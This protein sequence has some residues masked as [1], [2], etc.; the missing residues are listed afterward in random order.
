MKKIIVVLLMASAMDVAT[1]ASP[2][3]PLRVSRNGRHL[4][5][6]KGTPFLI[7]GDAPWSMTVNLTPT[8]M[9]TYFDDRAAK[10]MNTII[11]RVLDHDPNFD[12]NESPPG[13]PPQDYNGNQPFTKSNGDW[14]RRNEAYWQT[15][16]LLLAKA[17]A[18]DMLVLAAAAYLGNGCGGEGWCAEMLSQ[19]SAAMYDYGQF[20]GARYASQGNI[21][22]VDGG[23]ADCNRTD[24]ACDRVRGVRDGIESK[25]TAYLRTAHG[26]HGDSSSAEYPWITLRSVYGYSHNGEYIP[27]LLKLEYDKR[28]TRPVFMIESAYEN[29]HSSVLKDWASQS[30]WS[31]L[32]GGTGAVFGNRPIWL[33]DTGWD[34]SS[35]IDSPGSRQQGHI[36]DL[37]RS[38]FWWALIPDYSST[39]VTQG[40][41][42][43]TSS[44]YVPAARTANG[45]TVMAYIPDG[46]EVTVDMTQLSGSTAKAWWFDPVSAA[47]SLIGTFET[48]GERVF[49]PPFS[50]CVLVLD[51]AA[52]G[53]AAPGTTVY[54]F[55]GSEIARPRS[56]KPTA[57]RR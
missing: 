53:L 25:T 23:D 56:R 52:K 5:D 51:D 35:G 57:V 13:S 43:L 33:F 24:S 18:H 55:E 40:R 32:G 31:M 54:P 50:S 8:Q 47:T 3:W 20:I 10:G 28:P 9:D 12:Q 14:S 44:G 27:A 49:A 26:Q 42:S 22:W 11:L 37:M 45:E 6:Q 34:A 21:I 48:A 38:R 15:V 4:E 1:L 46:G 41:G 7:V 17:K 39:V 16:D 2:V 29:E 36:G 30:L 19:S